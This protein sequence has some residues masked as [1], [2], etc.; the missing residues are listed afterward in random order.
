M[1]TN[2]YKKLYF[3]TAKYFSSL[4]LYIWYK[5]TASDNTFDAIT[6]IARNDY[7]IKIPFLLTWWYH[8]CLNK[9]VSLLFHPKYILLK[10]TFRKL[11]KCYVCRDYTYTWIIFFYFRVSLEVMLHLIKI[12]SLYNQFYLFFALGRIVWVGMSLN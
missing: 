6:S 12:L 5:G 11:P 2:N 7:V 10:L 8:K 9:H 4:W 1:S 3:A